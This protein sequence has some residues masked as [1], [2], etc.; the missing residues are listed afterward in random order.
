MAFESNEKAE[1]L[2]AS[3]A[4][5]KSGSSSQQNERFLSKTMR[6]MPI[7]TRQQ[8]WPA[9]AFTLAPTTV[10]RMSRIA[11][12]DI[13]MYN[14]QAAGA[15]RY[16]FYSQEAAP[17][18]QFNI[19]NTTLPEPPQPPDEVDIMPKSAIDTDD[20]KKPP[21]PGRPQKSHAG[22]VVGSPYNASSFV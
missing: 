18:D 17:E 5:D 7:M 4:S 10:A 1:L 12:P 15:E 2:A 3:S 19:Y 16:A 14:A 21:S 8:D 9:S 13:L 11:K 22:Y 20:T 6:G